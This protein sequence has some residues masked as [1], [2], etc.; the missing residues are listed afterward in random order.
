MGCLVIFSTFN[1]L[2]K[3]LRTINFLSI[4]IHN[5]QDLCIKG[6]GEGSNESKVTLNIYFILLPHTNDFFS[7]NLHT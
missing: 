2:R 4:I 1:Y 6:G 5:T 7:I 3:V